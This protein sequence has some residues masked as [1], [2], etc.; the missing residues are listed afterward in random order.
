MPRRRTGDDELA[1]RHHHLLG[2]PAPT[3]QTVAV[4]C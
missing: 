2:L 4:L 3:E 1:V